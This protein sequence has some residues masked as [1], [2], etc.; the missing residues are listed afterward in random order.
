MMM[1]VKREERLVSSVGEHSQL[2]MELQY[3]FDTVSEHSE[4]VR[5]KLSFFIT[6]R[7][8]CVKDLLPSSLIIQSNVL[9]RL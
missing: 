9:L 4:S 3:W 2:T 8:K 6:T 7:N 5:D 1:F